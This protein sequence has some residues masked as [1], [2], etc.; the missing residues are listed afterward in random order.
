MPRWMKWVA[1][2]S[3]VV[4]VLFVATFI[5]HRHHYPYGW[6]HCCDKQLM[7]ALMNFAD[8]N[9]GWFP[10]G[11][12]S[13]EA[14]L[15]LLY[16]DDPASVSEN[17]LRGKI[18]PEDA[19][20]ARLKAGELLTPET[21]GWHYVE[22]LTSIAIVTPFNLGRSDTGETLI[23]WSRLGVPHWIRWLL[24]AMIITVPVWWFLIPH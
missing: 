24:A 10:K 19:V 4:V 23:N 20:R 17:C 6:S 22:G 14:S 2:M 16:R 11:E 7:A 15:S 21:C 12:A 18:V 9:D 1:V 8:Q 5:G 3:A 13:P